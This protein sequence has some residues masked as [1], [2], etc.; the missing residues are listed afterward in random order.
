MMDTQGDNEY[1]C[2]VED[3]LVELHRM[4]RAKAH[5]KVR[6]LRNEIDSL[7]SELERGLFYHMEPFYVACALAGNELDFFEHRDA[8]IAI[9]DR[10]STVPSLPIAE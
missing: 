9:S 7:E 6:K 5:S 10:Y 3:S 4:T 2:I 1:W 8:Y